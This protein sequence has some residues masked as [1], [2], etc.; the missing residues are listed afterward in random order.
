[1]G[2]V[3]PFSENENVLKKKVYKTHHRKFPSLAWWRPRGTLIV[4]FGDALAPLGHPTR[5]S[6]ALARL[7]KI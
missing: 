5:P 3:S 2:P 7:E 4:P 1:M 6:G